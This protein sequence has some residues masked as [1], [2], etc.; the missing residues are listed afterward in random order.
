MTKKE[1]SLDNQV[2]RLNNRVAVKKYYYNEMPQQIRSLSFTVANLETLRQVQMV[3]KSLENAMDEGLSFKEWKDNL[4]TDVLRQLS[5]ARLETVYR[6]NV[7]NVYNQSARYNAITSNVTP[8][9]MYTAVGDERTRP[10]HLELDG[11]IKRADSVFWDSHTP[12]LGFNCRC[13]T[14]PLSKEDAEDMGI[15]KQSNKS[16]PEADE[17][18]GSKKMG[19]MLST[20]EKETERAIDNLPNTSSLKSK[21]KEAQENVKSLVDIWFETKKDIFK[22]E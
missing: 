17:G 10:E 11:T 20:V 13:G 21:F 6:T 12:P 18:F 14:V 1:A 19:D 15:N 3:Q 2:A 8:Y 16:F 9:L 4:D 22:T 7:N 5:E